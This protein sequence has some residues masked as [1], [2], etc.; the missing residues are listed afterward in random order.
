MGIRNLPVAFC[1]EF[2]GALL[3]ITGA[4][5]IAYH[6]KYGFHCWWISN[7]CWIMV[8]MKTRR[9]GLVAM[10]VIYFIT[11]MLGLLLWKTT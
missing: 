3:G 5:L 4:V 9:Y 6:I 2:F 8:G 10:S 7:I 11:S 1:S